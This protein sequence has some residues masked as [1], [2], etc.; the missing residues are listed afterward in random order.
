[1]RIKRLRFWHNFNALILESKNA[2]SSL[3][4]KTV[5]N[6]FLPQYSVI[7]HSIEQGFSECNNKKQLQLQASFHLWLFFTCTNTFSWGYFQEAKCLNFV[8]F[9][10]IRI[11]TRFSKYLKADWQCRF[12]MRYFYVMELLRIRYPLY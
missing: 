7:K 6:S 8:T 3:S 12:A 1:M 4:N 2:I 5:Q 11:V 9:A 10:K